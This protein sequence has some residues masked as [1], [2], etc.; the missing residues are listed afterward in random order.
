[1]QQVEIAIFRS[2]LLTL[3][4]GD[5]KIKLLGSRYRLP[6]YMSVRRKPWKRKSCSGWK[7][8][9]LEER[10]LPPRYAVGSSQHSLLR[11]RITALYTARDL[12]AGHRDP[13]REELEFAL[14][15]IDSILRK[16]TKARDKYY[17]GSRSYNRFDPVVRDM[18]TLRAAILARLG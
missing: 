3:H 15:R 13:H 7:A 5:A 17:P 10:F 6:F 14:P 2:Y 18:E 11:N 12:I 9:S 1:M 8:F 4:L 16:T